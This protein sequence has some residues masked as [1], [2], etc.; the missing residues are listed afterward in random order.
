[1]TVWKKNRRSPNLFVTRV[2]AILV[3]KKNTKREHHASE[4]M[5][6]DSTSLY[7]SWGFSFRK[8]QTAP[9]HDIFLNN[10]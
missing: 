1:M 4:E 9:S 5:K 3:E 7:L 6:K 2:K 10:F 8:K